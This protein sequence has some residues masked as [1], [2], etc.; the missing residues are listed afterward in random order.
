MINN[1]NT[2]Y[3]LPDFIN[4]FVNKVDKMEENENGISDEIKKLI[5]E[6][7]DDFNRGRVSDK[8]RYYIV[9]PNG[10]SLYYT[11]WFHNPSATHYPYV[12]LTNLDLNAISSVN[13]AIKSVANS[14]SPLYMTS[15]LNN[16]LDNG[17]D[18]ISFGKYRGYHLYD[19]YTID[20]RYV[21]WIA[22][23]YEAHVKSE[24]RFKELAVTYSKVYL[25]L[26]T[27]R[28]YKKPVSGFVGVP[29]EKLTDLH[30][31]ITRVRIEDDPYK[32]RIIRGTE[33]FFVDQRLTAID[34]AGNYFLLTIKAKNGSLASGTVSPD[35]HAFQ[36][37][38]NLSI[39]S[40]KVLKHIE[41]R[42]IKYTRIGYVKRR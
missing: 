16:P 3:V 18:I 32:T 21:T 39:E 13:M 1:T 12:Y 23:K 37:G 10:T 2:N 7:L 42:D 20:P 24:A 15:E 38:E 9:S 31:L 11:L 22:D 14:F 25:D 4:I 27:R 17:D 19:I 30:L 28:K 33:Y 29:G 6:K 41:S 35:V 36:A 5:L 34:S 8:E 26:Q 40:A